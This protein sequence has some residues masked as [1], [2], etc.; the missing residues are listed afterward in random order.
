MG[1]T[2][3]SH[4]WQWGQARARLQSTLVTQAAPL[5]VLGVMAAILL[6]FSW[7]ALLWGLGLA[8]LAAVIPGLLVLLPWRLSS[9]LAHPTMA[10]PATTVLS[11]TAGILVE[12]ARLGVVTLQDVQLRDAVWLGLGVQLLNVLLALVL[13]TG[14][15]V[16]RP[17]PLD[18]E[19]ATEGRSDP[20]SYGH[21]VLGFGW[22]TLAQVGLSLL[23][24]LSPWLALV[25]VPVGAFWEALMGKG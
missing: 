4:S 25:T 16:L 23:L 18:L 2:T 1:L 24:A 14:K 22:S 21:G 12:L 6:G 3:Q 7:P 19:Q 17:S 5:L 8:I 15:V 11:L 20:Y 13:Y 10:G 9:D